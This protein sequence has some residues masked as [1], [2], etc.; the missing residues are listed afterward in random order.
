MSQT[1][2]PGG[3]FSPRKVLIASL[4]TTVVVFGVLYGLFLR[5]NQLASEVH[6]KHEMMLQLRSELT[7]VHL[8]LEELLAG[9]DSVS[10]E[11]IELRFSQATLTFENLE[12]AILSDDAVDEPLVGALQAMGEMLVEQYAAA[13]ARMHYDDI[14]SAGT[15]ADVD[16]DRVFDAFMLA[17]AELDTRLS[18]AIQKQL[19]YYRNFFTF[20]FLLVVG[21]W[22]IF[23]WVVYRHEVARFNLMQVLRD[24][25]SGVHTLINALPDLIWMKDAEGRYLRCNTKFER[26]F[27]ARE[28]NIVGR[29]DYDFVDSD[30]ADS[31]RENDRRAMEAGG[32]TI[33]EEE[34]IYSD[35][36]HSEFIE[37]TKTP[38]YDS[39]GAVLGVLGIGH[40]ITERRK[41][42]HRLEISERN[43]VEAQRISKLGSWELDVPTGALHWS[44]EVYS[45][46]G[47]DKTHHDN[48]YENFIEAI[49]PEDRELVDRE[50][51]ESLAN[52]SRYS[53]LHRLKPQSGLVKY[54][55]ERGESEYDGDNPIRTIGTVQDVTEQVESERRL[56]LMSQAINQSP[57]SVV[58]TDLK[59]SITYVNDSFEQ[60]T[61]FSRAEVIGRN[62]SVLGAE[63]TPKHIYQE[64][65]R[66]LLA[67]ESYTCDIRNKKK[68]G[69]IFWERAH[70]S[71]VLNDQGELFSY[72]SVKEDISEQKQQE[73]KIIYQA[74]YDV[75]T[76]L[77]NRFLCM[78][79]LE[80]LLNEAKREGNKLALLFVDL[81]DFKKV[82]D[83]L[84][85]DVGDKL[86]VQ[87]A[88]RVKELVRQG[89]TVGRLGGDE[90]VVIFNG[91]ER[92]EDVHPLVEKILAS[93]KA[94]FAID[95]RELVVT[96]SVGV[97]IYP[98]D[99]DSRID[100]SELLRK[101]DAAMYHS[102][103]S[104]R[105]T[106]SFYTE[107]MNEN[108]ARR[109]ELEEQM[110]GAL[111]RDEFS[112]L[113]Q[114][115]ID[116][117]DGSV[118]GV[119]AL[120]RWSNP[121]LGS[122]STP[123]F[124]A[125]AE[126][127]GFIVDIGRFVIEVALQQMAQ[128]R[129]SKPDFNVAINLSPRQFREPSLV[130]F[131]R[132]QIEANSLDSG[133]VE[134]EI[135]EGVLLSG[136]EYV[137]NALAALN[138]LGV[139][140]AMD[141]FG[142]GYSSLSYLR[143]YPFDV[144]KIDRSFVTDIAFDDA[145]RKL[146]NAAVAM[147]H[148]MGLRVVAEGVE[149]EAQASHLREIGCDYAQGYLYSR[150]VAADDITRMLS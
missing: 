148:S 33:N 81:D 125:L 12:K 141:D 10:G 133:C 14:S 26:F 85:H 113:Y 5:S 25:E 79:R 2:F 41:A 122:V 139:R 48:T 123:E 45:I 55:L 105:N 34:V 65:W 17:A 75:L 110:H 22:L 19:D 88:S 27:G 3:L 147:G 23:L 11:D 112:L 96:A 59:G 134:M 145:D 62:A 106:Y 98:D 46:F 128:W 83:S 136:H 39:N 64:M 58:V 42:Q 111:K 115:K 69:E 4:I 89:D 130:P 73:Q 93:L 109:L 8:M 150:P 32:P 117:S 6:S 7:L 16:Y 31:F 87:T 29:T 52:K 13:K 30:L 57:I 107:A 102:K 131:L 28:A 61:G 135:T 9:D 37:T 95:G 146:I 116:L 21:I 24:N 50:F 142:T 104:G 127:N 86:L 121:V 60:I 108:I 120:V 43:L 129:I 132:E 137:A 51:K 47:L 124:I 144:L 74:N 91:V 70:F 80:Y 90:F 36:G 63:L 38:I 71:P 53:I 119:E 68:S 49:H 138:D 92:V 143:S 18:G 54:V 20:C 84:G 82:N 56:K 15:P 44:D 1:E 72:L 78:D 66:A 77:P 140:I 101:S 40:D 99:T 126:Q 94:P 67:G 114:P 103:S 118:M 149:T 100:P 76:D 35:D 97:A